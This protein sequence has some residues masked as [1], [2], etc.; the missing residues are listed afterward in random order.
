MKRAVHYF[1]LLTFVSAFATSASTKLSQLTNV[2]DVLKTFKSDKNVK[3][4][5]E[6]V[7]SNLKRA[8][9]MGIAVGTSKTARKMEI[10]ILQL[11]NE[12]IKSIQGLNMKQTMMKYKKIEDTINR[13]KKAIEIL[14]NAMKLASKTR[15]LREY[16]QEL[17]KIS[18]NEHKANS[19]RNKDFIPKSKKELMKK[20]TGDVN[21]HVKFLRKTVGET[22]IDMQQKRKTKQKS[23]IGSTP[24]TVTTIDTPIK[25]NFKHQTYNFPQFYIRMPIWPFYD[26]N[27]E[28]FYQQRFRRQNDDNDDDVTNEIDSV[29]EKQQENDEEEDMFGD[30]FDAPDIGGGSLAGLIGSLSGGE[31]GKT[32]IYLF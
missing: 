4:L 32:I 5:V 27:V 26:G 21:E 24:S 6:N 14:S 16:R 22:I 12:F 3:N 11:I 19:T 23:E 29:K 10:N 31:G 20:L 13:D 1:I 18:E 30:G 17:N 8:A 9:S 2:E 28:S 15:T 25:D 7:Q